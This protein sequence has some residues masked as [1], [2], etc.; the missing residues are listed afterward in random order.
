[1]ETNTSNTTTEPAKP[2]I[3]KL[4]LGL[5]NAAIWERTT[6]KSTFY[7]VSFERRYK[8]GKGEWQSTSSYDTENLLLL[9]KL[10]DQAHSK[11]VELQ[12]GAAE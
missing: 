2:P 4:R 3:A 10:A 12:T 7:S 11:I 5:L 1:M 9:A 8:D 6:D